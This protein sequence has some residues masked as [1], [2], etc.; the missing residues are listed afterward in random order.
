MCVC[1]CVCVCN[2]SQHQHYTMIIAHLL[3][4]SAFVYC[5]ITCGCHGMLWRNRLGFSIVCIS[6]KKCV[7]F[8]ETTMLSF[9]PQLEVHLVIVLNLLFGTSLFAIAIVL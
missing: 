4:N 5:V 1:V 6:V 7:V 9:G 2:V 3:I 8:R